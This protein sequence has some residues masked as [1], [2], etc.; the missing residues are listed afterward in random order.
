MT[1][2]IIRSCNFAAAI[3]LSA[4][5]A[6]SATAQEFLT[7][8]ELLATI[9][10]NT[11]YGIS[12][13]DGKTRWIQ[14]YGKGRKKGKIAGIYGKNK[15]ESKWSVKGNLWCEDWGTGGGC[16]NFEKVD[17]K[18]YRVYKDGKP[19]KNLWKLK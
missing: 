15:Y 11:A 9:P 19:L 2:S 14:N 1:Y 5:V 3:M 12:N 18:S 7:Q 8:K 17:S 13:E 4:M 10:G 6:S 16:W